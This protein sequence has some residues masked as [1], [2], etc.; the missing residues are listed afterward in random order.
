MIKSIQI[1]DPNDLS[2]NWWPKVETLAGVNTINFTPGV[3]ILFAP[4]GSGKSTVLKVIANQLHCLQGGVST[5]TQTSVRNQSRPGIGL[6][7]CQGAIV[8][9]DGQACRYFNPAKPVGLQS[10]QF[11]DDFF[12]EGMDNLMLKVSAGQKTMHQISRLVDKADNEVDWRVSPDRC[13]DVWKQALEEIQG[14]MHGTIDAGPKTILMD[15][16][17]AY[18][19]WPNRRMFWEQVAKASEA[20]KAQFIIATHSYFGLTNEDA[21][22]VEL[23][24]GYRFQAAQAIEV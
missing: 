1:H 2:T 6:K 13:N 19:D 21:N 15:E 23:V 16:P 8:N 14:Q 9:H 4:N 18:M 17:D 12:S 11:D 24:E 20:G 7:I 10:G 22:F 3:N 5:I